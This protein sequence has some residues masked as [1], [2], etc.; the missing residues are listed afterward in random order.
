MKIRAT[1]APFA[2]A[3][4]L[5][6]T[7]GLAAAQETVTL[8]VHHFLGPQ[9]TAHK[10]LFAP[11]CDKIAKESNN[12]LKCQMY[13]AMQLG[14]TPPQLFDQVRDGVADIVWTI[15]TYQAGR[16]IKSE[17]FEL[18]F[19]VKTAKGGSR[20][21]WEY[22][23]QHASD[24]FKGVKVL[25]AHVHDGSELHFVKQNVAT[26]EDIK[27]LKV[28]AATRIN[29]RMLA[30]IG[31]V[32]VQMPVPQVPEALAKGVID[33]ASLPWEVVPGLKV[34]EV[35]KFHT[36]VGPGKPKV[37]NS[38]FVVAMNE[39]KYNS[40]PADLKK[41][42]DANSGV[43]AS[44]WAGEVWDGTVAPGRKTATD[45]GNTITILSDAEF[46]RWEKATASVDDEWIKDVSAKGADGKKLLEAAKALL[47]Q[48]DK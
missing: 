8:K 19:M 20:A 37:S 31:A 4:G 41:V 46:Q 42:I 21:F 12:R 17:V 16:F 30:A 6:F 28:R 26:L 36:E 38:I 3:L 24:E 47:N 32:P 9:S 35:T 1:L 29:S 14:G 33:G 22:I 40:L 45:R 27:G 25:I 2:V 11:W 43:E 15:P 10:L 23:Q 39:A 48:Y 13:P 44:V 7:A 5:T 18:P 34:Q